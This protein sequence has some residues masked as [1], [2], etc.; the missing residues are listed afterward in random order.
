MQKIK[1]NSDLW[2]ESQEVVTKDG[3][4][5][6]ILKTDADNKFPVI[7]CVN[8]QAKHFSKRGICADPTIGDLYVLREEELTP[9]EVRVKNL[10]LLAVSIWTMGD[11]V[12]GKSGVV[13]FEKEMARLKP[14]PR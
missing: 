8:G 6:E 13:E 11:A 7:G 12:I 4:P 2:L 5:V 14:L 3:T 10:M 9:Y 1:F